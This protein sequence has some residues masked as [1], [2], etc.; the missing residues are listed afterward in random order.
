LLSENDY[1]FQESIPNAT[2]LVDQTIEFLYFRTENHFTL[3][4]WKL[5][6][7][8]NYVTNLIWIGL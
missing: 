2:F 8:K 7:T 4:L 1:L 3:L 6:K 5:A